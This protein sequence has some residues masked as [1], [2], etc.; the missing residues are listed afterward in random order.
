MLVLLF[1]LYGY[2]HAE[3]AL[4]GAVALRGTYLHEARL[5]GAAD[6]SYAHEGVLHAVDVLCGVDGLLLKVVPSPCKGK[7]IKMLR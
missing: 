7:R 5:G 2:G 4:V 1:D 6:G 3:Q